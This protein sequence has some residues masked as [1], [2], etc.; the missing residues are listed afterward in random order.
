MIHRLTPLISQVAI[1]KMDR[2]NKLL[3]KG[4]TGASGTYILP[5]ENH[6]IIEDKEVDLS[7]TFLLE[8]ESVDKILSL[9]G[10]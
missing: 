1:D 10:L 2:L 3:I 5:I 7:V 9:V 4:F 8:K 6:L